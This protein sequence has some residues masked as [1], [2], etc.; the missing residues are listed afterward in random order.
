MPICE[1]RGVLK[2]NQQTDIAT[3][4]PALADLIDTI[5][6]LP[7]NAGLAASTQ[8]FHFAIPATG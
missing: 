1:K 2:T 8:D 6:T 5:R 7:G 4:H 3:T